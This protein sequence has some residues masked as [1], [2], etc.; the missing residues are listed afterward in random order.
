MLKSGVYLLGKNIRKGN[1][2][3]AVQEMHTL[4]GERG[5]CMEIRQEESLHL[6]TLG[7]SQA[8]DAGG[9]KAGHP[10]VR[11]FGG[12]Y[13]SDYF[14][15]LIWWKRERRITLAKQGPSPTHLNQLVLD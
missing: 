9:G 1:F 10:S 8:F 13:R 6:G 3:T 12:A 11:R 4:S 15:R 5:A 2:A 7:H 14:R